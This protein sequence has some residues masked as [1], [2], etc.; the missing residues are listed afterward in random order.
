MRLNRTTGGLRALSALAILSSGAMLAAAP[1]FSASAEHPGQSN[2]TRGD[3][4]DFRRDRGHDRARDRDRDWR[5]GHDRG[6][7]IIR[8]Y[9]DDCGPS[10]AEIEFN[11]G[12]LDGSRAGF[13]QGY[14][15]GLHGRDAH[16]V[17]TI[18]LDRRSKHYRAGFLAGFDAGYDAGY[19]AGKRECARLAELERRRRERDRCGGFRIVD[20][21]RIDWRFRF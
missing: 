21:F 12:R 10:Y 13:D 16:C 6:R 18:N 2:R 1:A 14:A 20:G 19:L 8:H 15:D 4:R 3:G 7:V 17:C 9:D 11:R 5:R